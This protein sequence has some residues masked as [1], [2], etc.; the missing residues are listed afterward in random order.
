MKYL[1]LL[2]LISQS[3]LLSAQQTSTNDLP[4]EPV[5]DTTNIDIKS[6]NSFYFC[7]KLY[8]IPRDCE[9]KDQSKC[10]SFSGHLRTEEKM[11]S[12]QLGCYN[13]TSLFWMYFKNEEEAK[14]NLENYAPQIKKQMK[15]FSQKE[16]KL[17]LCGQET[18]AYKI[19]YV[20]ME[21]HNGYQINAYG[22]INGQS[23]F[24]QL[25]ST[26]ELKSSNEIQSVFQQIVKF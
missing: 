17:S 13:G 19:N 21:G 14:S 2:F 9:G 8:K 25:M 10:C 16:I 6:I 11:S 3:A 4:E 1:I 26:K 23:V 18:T 20:T 12:G 24:I 7:S 5:Y 22:T 15:K